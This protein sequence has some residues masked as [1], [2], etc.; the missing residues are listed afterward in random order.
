MQAFDL[1]DSKMDKLSV[2]VVNITGNMKNSQIEKAE[3]KGT[4]GSFDV[5]AP[6]IS[7][8]SFEIMNGSINMGKGN[9]GEL[10]AEV[11][12]VRSH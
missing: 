2:D 3:V 1:T 8:G 4:N 6:H 7:Q 11:I 12:M 5:D 10:S 9:T